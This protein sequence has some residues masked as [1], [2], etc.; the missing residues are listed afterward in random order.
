M[1]ES[2]SVGTP[3]GD[4]AASDTDT[5]SVGFRLK[6]NPMRSLLAR[7]SSVEPGAEVAPKL[8]IGTP[9]VGV[10]RAKPRMRYLK[11]I[12]PHLRTCPTLNNSHKDRDNIPKREEFM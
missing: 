7:R 12:E 3:E 2:I 1:E 10:H 4:A 5:S 6:A 9:P 8:L 11:K